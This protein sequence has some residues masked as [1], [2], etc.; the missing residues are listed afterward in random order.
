MS[1]SVPSASHEGE[2][3]LSVINGRCRHDGG[4]ALIPTEDGVLRLVGF[5]GYS[6]DLWSLEAIGPDGVA[7]WTQLT[8]IELDTLLPDD[9]SMDSSC[10]TGFAK[11]PDSNVIFVNTDVGVF[12]IGL[13]SHSARKVCEPDGDCYEYSCIFPYM[14]FFTPDFGRGG[15]L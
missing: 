2:R 15:L 4:I 14:S 10:M 1:T 13:E 3:G 8:E 12:M 9:D 5:M 7:M 11:A 6:L